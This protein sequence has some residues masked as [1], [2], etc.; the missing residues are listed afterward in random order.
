[1]G[2]L[3]DAGAWTSIIGALLGALAIYITIRIYRKTRNIEKEQRKNAE[4][5]YVIKTQDYLRKI[6]NHFDQI[7]KTVENH[8]RNNEEDKQLITQELN[9]YF[10]K[11]HGEMI[12][13]F[14]SSERSLEL[15]VSLDHVVRD[16]FDKIVSEFDWLTSKF[17]PL[18]VTDDG[19][20]I[21]IW[22]TEYDAFLEKK[23]YIDSI[24]EKELKAEG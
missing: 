1:M 24:L 15:W 6:Q 20:R 4:G 22:T 18:T 5:L 2:L 12:K 16:K 8:D 13:L 11:Y 3:E 23:Y 10:R 17:F 7:F 21:R 19:T 14:Q 9:L